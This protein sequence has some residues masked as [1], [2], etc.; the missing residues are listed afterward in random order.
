MHLFGSLSKT[1]KV[2]K[3]GSQF[4]IGNEYLGFDSFYCYKVEE[5]EDKIIYYFN[6]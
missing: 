6:D 5:T 2:F 1:N 4:V 3:K